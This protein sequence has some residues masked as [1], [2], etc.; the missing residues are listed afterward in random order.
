[1]YL[2]FT[3]EFDPPQSHNLCHCQ[4][5]KAALWSCLQR[6]SLEWSCARFPI[7]FAVWGRVRESHLKPALALT[8]FSQQCPHAL[9]ERMNARAA[10]LA[11]LREGRP[12][13]REGAAT[14]QPQTV[15]SP[16]AKLEALSATSS[17][18]SRLPCG[19]W[20]SLNA[21]LSFLNQSGA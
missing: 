10:H 1:M 3:A 11:S 2:V 17:Q 18:L 16:A 20:S 21:V 8:V 15:F 13:R 14:S 6:A 19:F 5:S 9:F 7:H 12:R 4:V